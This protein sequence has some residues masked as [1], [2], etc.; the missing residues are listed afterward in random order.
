[1]ISVRAGNILGGGDW[2]DDRIIPDIIKAYVGNSQLTIRN[3]L[4]I[5]PWQHVFD[6]LN[7]YL[8]LAEKSYS[9][10]QKFSGAW[11]FGPNQNIKKSVQDILNYFEDH[12]DLKYHI[13]NLNQH[14]LEETKMLCLDTSKSEQIL[15]FYNKLNFEEILN[16]TLNWY[17]YWIKNPGNIFQYSLDSIESY[18]NQ[19]NLILQTE[20]K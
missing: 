5:R 20:R 12:L 14:N 1:M 17:K 13:D 18:L 15:K 4:S 6:V 3:P 19:H 11:N 2:S 16:L 7:G 8:L 9:K 10:P